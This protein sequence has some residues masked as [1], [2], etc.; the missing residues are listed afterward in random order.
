METHVTMETMPYFLAFFKNLSLSFGS[1]VFSALTELIRDFI[2][3]QERPQR[4]LQMARALWFSLLQQDRTLRPLSLFT[5]LQVPL[6]NS[7][8]DAG[9]TCSGTS[10]SASSISTLVEL[11]ISDQR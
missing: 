2:P 8:P 6:F 4:M 1:F 10:S 7:S 11:D 9:M 3:M 5:S